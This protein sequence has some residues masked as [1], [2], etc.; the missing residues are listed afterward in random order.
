M[1][2][3]KNAFKA[4]KRLLIKIWYWLTEPHPDIRERDQRRVARL[5]SAL[6]LVYIFLA[7]VLESITVLLIN[8]N[9]TY[10]GYRQTIVVVFLLL[11]AYG[12]SRTRHFRGAAALT[13]FIISGGIFYTALG[14]PTGILG[15]LLD[16]LIIPIWFGSLFFRQRV[17]IY[18][19]LVQI[20]SMLAIPLFVPTI[21]Y[22]LILIG[23]VGFLL[24]V[25]VP[26]FL[27]IRYRDLLEQ[28]RQTNLVNSELRFR[29]EAI[30]AQALLRVA[31]RLN[32][33]LDQNILLEAVC[34]EA[35][36][37]LDTPVVILELY[38]QKSDMLIPSACAG[39][40]QD[41]FSKVPPLTLSDLESGIRQMEGVLTLMDLQD[42]ATLRK[43][44]VFENL[45]LRSLVVGN[46]TYEGSLIGCIAALT[47]GASQVFDEDHQLLLKGIC[48]QSALA[49]VNTR[50][51]K[52][53]QRRLEHLQ[54]LRA[55]DVAIVT[56]HT[57][58]ETLE[59]LLEQITRRL[60]VDAA[61]ILLLDQKTQ[62]LNYAASRGL[63]TN[64]LKYTNLR[65]GEGAAGQAAET[66]GI[67]YLSNMQEDPQAFRQSPLFASE[68][69]TTYFAAP[70]IVKDQ[71]K[72]VL[73]ILHRTP[74]D[75]DEEWLAFLEAMAGQAAIA[76]D[77]STLFDDLQRTNQE[78]SKAY[79]ST[80]EGWSRALD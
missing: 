13:L 22:N 3:P 46:I 72:G 77:N 53:A 71:L 34:E 57:L 79:D 52:D 56:N 55:I 21:S 31:H 7:V 60:G 37:A 19:I 36:K 68:K 58:H 49:I 65:I 32:A 5:L 6:V 33:H 73:E 41:D 2:I 24:A 17:L 45:N 47:V 35:A 12:T 10:S 1:Q 26:L 39:L 50:L 76:I 38:D 25:S 61:V 4:G 27:M 78:L 75:P 59:V 42:F 15:G 16:Y 11:I 74:F 43:I 23:P 80:I 54:A 40:S 29:R 30:R 70:L 62:L 67:H 63:K 69:I 18:L 8:G 20:V 9:E 51:Y 44:K 28:D 64:P 66:Q 48:D 14:E